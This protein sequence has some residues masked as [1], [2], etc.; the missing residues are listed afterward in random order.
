MISFRHP[1]YLRQGLEG[2]DTVVHGSLDIVHVV[3]GGSANNDR[4]NSGNLF[5]SFNLVKYK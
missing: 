4:G 3:I 1:N 2:V 5:S